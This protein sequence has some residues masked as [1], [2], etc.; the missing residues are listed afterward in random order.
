MNMK[1]KTTYNII[2]LLEV[3]L[4]FKTNFPVIEKDLFFFLN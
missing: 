1:I 4:V 3:W 2:T